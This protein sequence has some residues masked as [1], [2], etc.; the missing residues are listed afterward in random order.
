MTNRRV[1]DQNRRS[2]RGRCRLKAAFQA[3]A[4]RRLQAAAD[5][6]TDIFDLPNRRFNIDQ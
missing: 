4:E 2:D 5:H 1:C 6:L 3:R